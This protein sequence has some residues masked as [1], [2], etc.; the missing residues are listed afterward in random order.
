VIVGAVLL[1]VCLV[2]VIPAL[3]WAGIGLL[4]YGASL[5]L[6]DNAERTHQGSELID[7]NI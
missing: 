4:A 6:T 1:A 5:T 2:A 3:V 7:T